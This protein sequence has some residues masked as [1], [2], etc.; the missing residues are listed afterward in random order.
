MERGEEIIIED[1]SQAKEKDWVMGLLR[2][3]QWVK[4]LFY[5]WANG[6]NP[7]HPTP[8][9]SDRRCYSWAQGL[10]YTLW[11]TGCCPRKHSLS[12]NKALSPHPLK[13]NEWLLKVMLTLAGEFWGPDSDMRFPVHQMCHTY[14]NSNLVQWKRR[15]IIS[16][17]LYRENWGPGACHMQQWAYKIGNSRG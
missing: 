8:T 5:M 12:R 2:I 13:R 11:M 6:F 15:L 17:K 10:E 16:P 1:S 7:Q 4:A 3:A 9:K 14:F